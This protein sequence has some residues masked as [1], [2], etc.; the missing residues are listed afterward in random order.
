MVKSYG[1]V[2]VVGGLWDFSVKPQSE[3]DFWILNC[4]S[5]NLDWVWAEADC[6]YTL[7]P[8]KRQFHLGTLDFHLKR[9]TRPPSTRTRPT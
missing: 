3:L 4:F 2:V 9:R 5:F 1:W 6:L 8:L 7:P